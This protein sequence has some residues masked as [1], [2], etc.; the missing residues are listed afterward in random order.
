MRKLEFGL[1]GLAILFALPFLVTWPSLAASWL[2]YQL[3]PA[4]SSLGLWVYLPAFLTEI[5]LSDVTRYLIVSLAALALTSVALIWLV[6]R[7]RGQVWRRK[8]LYALLVVLAAVL[9]FP[10]LMRYRPAVEAAPGVELRVV[11]R[12]GLLAGAVRMCQAGAEVRG[13]QY[14]PLGWADSQTLVYR[15]WCG[16]YYTVEGDRHAGIPGAPQAYHLD[17]G[18]V[19]PF[20]GDVAALL[21]EP[22]SRSTCVY[23]GLAEMYPG[24]G[25]FPGQ[26]ETP[27]LSPDGRWVAFTAAHVYGPEDLLVLSTH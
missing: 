20:E 4:A 3:F 6:A 7:E 8:R 5:L 22:C 23:S 11:E 24:G 2:L 16:G 17:S 15:K 25:Y 18:A 14:E 12:P 21:R 9:V 10:L 13:C 1:L 27:L 26:Y 19:A